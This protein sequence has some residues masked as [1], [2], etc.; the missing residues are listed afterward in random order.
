VGENQKK[1][2]I[3][4]QAKWCYTCAVE[5]IIVGPVLNR[6]A[7]C[8]PILRALPE[9]FG[10]EEAI[11]YYV[12]EI[13]HLP[14]FLAL[15]KAQTAVGFVSLKLHSPYAAEVY[16]MAVRPEAHRMGLGRALLDQAD[17]YLRSLNVE[18]VQVKTLSPSHPDPHYARTRAFYQA[19]GFRPLEEMPE[20][21]GERNPCLILIRRL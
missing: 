18:Y 5:P 6:A 12:A 2:G 16:V 14:T 9:W 21:W 7:D 11:V 17:A 3:G 15:D 4:A 8:E 1:Q 20:L 13:N 19:I 10:I